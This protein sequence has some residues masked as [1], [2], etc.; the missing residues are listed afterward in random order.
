VKEGR[1]MASD[2]EP[3]A[4]VNETWAYGILPEKVRGLEEPQE[5]LEPE[6]PEERPDAV[7]EYLNSIA[8]YPLLTREEEVRLGLAVKTWLKLKELRQEFQETY[9]REPG[10]AELAIL[11]YEELASH[12]GALS[13]LAAVVGEGTDSPSLAGLLSRPRIRIALDSALD[14]EVKDALAKATNEPEETVIANVAAISALSR[15]LPP[16]LTGMLEADEGQAPALLEGHR[17]TLEK[18][19]QR[20]EAEG[21][22]ASERLINCNLRLVVSVARRYLRWGLPILDLIQEG[23][24]GL[25]RAVDKF[26]PHLGYR[27]STYA[28]WWVRQ[29][30]TRALGSAG[31]TIRLPEH[32]LDRVQKLYETELALLMQMGRDPTV[33]EL[34]GELGWPE[35]AVEDLRRQRQITVSLET[36]VGGEEEGTLADFLPDVSGW[37]PDEQA[38][39]RLTRQE[40]MEAL[41]ELS[42]RLRRVV[43]LRFGFLDDRPRTLEEVGRELG[44]TRERVRQLEKQALKKLQT[45]KKLAPVLDPFPQNALPRAESRGGPSMAELLVGQVTHY[46]SRLG[47]ASLNLRA[48]LNKGDLIHILGRTTDLKEAVDSLEI[49][50]QPIDLARPGDDVAIKVAGKVRDGDKVY[51]ELEDGGSFTVRDL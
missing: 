4:P 32:I 45:S 3:L 27:F 24:L 15:L 47:V 13:A 8:R 30:I 25:M 14:A 2:Q 34:A 23:N 36:P 20:I 21:Q 16:P 5:I 11:I 7:T 28:T 22:A 35:A 41:E 33:Q 46:Y 49:D 39:A 26:N 12:R 31:R 1:V 18:W 10:P 29:A 37:S 17:P 44:V 43:L 51:R 6:P 50:H 48:P 9:L 19:W 38:V 42:P 40:V